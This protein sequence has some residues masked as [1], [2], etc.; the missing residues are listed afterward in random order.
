MLDIAVIRDARTGK[1]AKIPKVHRDIKSHG[2]G[3]P[4]WRR[5]FF[6][7]FLC[8]VITQDKTHG[9]CLTAKFVYLY[10]FV[11]EPL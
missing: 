7:L 9:R 6:F 1:Y 8:L 4:D 2:I 5:F 10:Q 11:S 3:A